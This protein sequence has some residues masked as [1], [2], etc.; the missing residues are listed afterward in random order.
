MQ[1]LRYGPILQ[2]YN[3]N[4]GV[5]TEWQDHRILLFT[6]CYSTTEKAWANTVVSSLKVKNTLMLLSN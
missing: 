6:V 5:K 2:N 1:L 4:F 3:V